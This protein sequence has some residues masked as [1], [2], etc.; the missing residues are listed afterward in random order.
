LQFGRT[1][2]GLIG[3][4]DSDFAAD[5]D[6]RSLTGYVFT[7]GGCAISWRA[8]LQPTVAQSTTEAV[9]IGVCDACKED[10]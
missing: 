1:R 7:I 2:E 3:Y 9:Y 4:V 5:L 10:V 8:W 6:K